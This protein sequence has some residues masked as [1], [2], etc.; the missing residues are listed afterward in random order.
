MIAAVVLALAHYSIT[1]TRP[2]AQQRFDAGLTYLYAFDGPDA[3]I[4]F[5]GAALTDPLLA[6]AFWGKALADGSDLNH[7]ITEERFARAQA[8]IARATALETH[9]S[10][11]E[12]ELI[13]AATLRYAGTYRNA[14]R[15]EAAY[16]TAMRA[17]IAAHPNDDDAAM[18][19]VE[20]LLESHGMT[21]TDGGAPANPVGVEVVNIVHDVLARDPTHLFANHLCIH[22]YDTAPDRT[23]AIDCARR[24][25]A[26]TFGPGEEHLAHM[27]AHLWLEIGDG[28]KAL[29]SSARAWALHPTEYAAHDAYVALLA[30]LMAG[31]RAAALQWSTR[32]A[33]L[34]P[35]H[36]DAVIDARTGDWSGAKSKLHFAAGS[37]SAAVLDARSDE[38]RGNV[39]GAIARLLPLEHSV[40]LAGE[41]LPFFP[42]D[43]ALGAIYYRAGRFSEAAQTFDTIL[44]SRPDDPRALFGMWQTS[45]ALSDTANATRCAELFAQYWAGGTLTMNDF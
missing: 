6:I 16:E 31:D 42:P 10:P 3:A 24:L 9:A 35:Y 18:L 40:R 41:M 12:R 36:E 4:E 38:A 11:S 7:P 30:A 25:D 1:T 14:V 15:D 44:A 43:E 29:A 19:L 37:P 28:E 45:L 21:W 23:F 13:D 20:A 32:L 26:M 8:D 2:L 34:G 27:P 5:D 33:A 17:Y 22:V 39:A